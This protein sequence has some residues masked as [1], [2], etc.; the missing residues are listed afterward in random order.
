MDP[1]TN[2][3]GEFV[4]SWLEMLSYCCYP[5]VPRGNLLQFFF[6][7]FGG[8]GERGGALKTVFSYFMWLSL[9]V[10]SPA[11][12]SPGREHCVSVLGKAINSLS[13]SPSTCINGYRRTLFLL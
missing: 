2:K 8:G 5:D 7:F 13:A 6:F 1:V 4:Y 10:R 11:D 9:L 12:S 3:D